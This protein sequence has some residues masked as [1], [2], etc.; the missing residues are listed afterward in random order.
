MVGRSVRASSYQNIYLIITQSNDRH[1]YRPY[2][3]SFLETIREW[4]Q[5]KNWA[6]KLFARWM[7]MT[8]KSYATCNSYL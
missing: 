4:V 2:E 6:M 3:Q 1:N 5:Q 7:R 8:Y